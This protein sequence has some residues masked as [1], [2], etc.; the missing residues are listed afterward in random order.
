MEPIDKD[1]G[2]DPDGSLVA[3][4]REKGAAAAL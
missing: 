2:I 3:R 1:G 4:A